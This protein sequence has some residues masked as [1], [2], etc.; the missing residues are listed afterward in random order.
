MLWVQVLFSFLPK[1]CMLVWVETVDLLDGWI[2][3]VFSKHSPN[4]LNLTSVL[5]TTNFL[6]HINL[7][8][9]DTWLHPI[10][11]F[12]SFPSMSISQYHTPNLSIHADSV[13]FYSLQSPPSFVA[14]SCRDFTLG[15]KKEPESA[16]RI[17]L[18]QI[19][20]YL[21]PSSDWKESSTQMRVI[22]VLCSDHWS[23]DACLGLTS[24]HVT[25]IVCLFVQQVRKNLNFSTN[26]TLKTTKELKVKGVMLLIVERESQ[27]SE[28]MRGKRRAILTSVVMNPVLSY[29]SSLHCAWQLTF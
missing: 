24:T 23:H 13:C 7:L 25:R 17:Y 28:F 8:S 4:V 10:S 18:S 16:V 2:L 1:T 20:V 27:R 15:L 11:I 19:V 21:S 29:T 22:M 26:W 14:L 5:P 12:L 3:F 9:P 6:S